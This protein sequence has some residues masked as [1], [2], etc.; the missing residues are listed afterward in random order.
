MGLV[1][2]TTALNQAAYRAEVGQVF[3]DSNIMVVRYPTFF[4]DPTDVQFTG[5][6]NSK[7]PVVNTGGVY[8]TPVVLTEAQSASAIL[9]NDAAGLDFTLPAIAAAQIGL[10]YK[11]L[12]TV[13]VTSNNF[14]VTAA[15][16]DLLLG[17]VLMADFDAAYTAPQ[18]VYLTP[19]GSSH[20]VLTCN[21]TTTGGKKGTAVEFI[22]V[23][24]TGWF[25][26]GLVFGDGVL[27]TPFS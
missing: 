27:A 9:V 14:R 5:A 25:V 1:Y 26:T 23:S 15:S 8:A 13:S 10:S 21:G 19:N 17:S 4:T 3:E 24:A 2:C 6:L 11:F 16:G 12:V 7:Y 18:G 20:L 22:A